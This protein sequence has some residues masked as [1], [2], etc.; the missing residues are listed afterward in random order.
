VTARRTRHVAREILRI[1]GRLAVTGNHPLLLETGWAPASA[2]AVGDRMRLAS[3][4]LERVESV[5][6]SVG[7]FLVIDLA[8]SPSHTFVVSGVVVHNKT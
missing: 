3:G 6:R 7:R 1:N 5:E 8:V 4:A 2:V